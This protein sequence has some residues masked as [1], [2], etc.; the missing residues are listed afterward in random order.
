MGQKNYQVL[1][2]AFNQALLPSLLAS[3]AQRNITSLLVEGGARTL[4]GFLQLGLWDEARVLVAGVHLFPGL[5]APQLPLAPES[6]QK[7]GNDFLLAYQN[8]A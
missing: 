6:I 1:E 7:L 8:H 4:E 5:P 2:L 3:L